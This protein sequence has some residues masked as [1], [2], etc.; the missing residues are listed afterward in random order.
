MLD[1]VPLGGGGG[2]AMPGESIV[3]A[4]A[5]IASAIVRIATALARR[6]L[7]TFLY[8]PHAGHVVSKIHSQVEDRTQRLAQGSDSSAAA[9]TEIIFSLLGER[10]RMKQSRQ[11]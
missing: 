6:K 3:P 7:V 9:S 10:L 4:N 5:E 11:P 1:D 2:D 8:L